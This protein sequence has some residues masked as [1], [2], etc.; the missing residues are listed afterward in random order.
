MEKDSSKNKVKLYEIKCQ[1]DMIENAH[2]QK[3]KKKNYRIKCPIAI[4]CYHI[5]LGF[6][7]LICCCCCLPI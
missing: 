3:E 4:Q 2:A 7:L 6:D 1:Y 5:K